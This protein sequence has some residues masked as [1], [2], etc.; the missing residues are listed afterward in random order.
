MESITKEQE[1]VI[2]KSIRKSLAESK[3]TNEQRE[4]ILNRFMCEVFNSGVFDV[5]EIAN[6][7]LSVPDEF[8]T[9]MTISGGGTITT[10]YLPREAAD[11]QESADE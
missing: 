5:S 8:I 4:E 9:D 2:M 7:F 11:D 3:V 6:A 10:V 1:Q